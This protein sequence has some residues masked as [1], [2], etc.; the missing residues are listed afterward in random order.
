[1][2]IQ[3]CEKQQCL[4]ECSLGNR[5]EAKINTRE[6]TPETKKHTEQR[7]QKSQLS[8]FLGGME[9]FISLS[10][11]PSLSS[12]FLCLPFAQS[13]I[14]SA[15]EKGPIGGWREIVFSEEML[16]APTGGGEDISH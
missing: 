7:R 6:S 11:S 12:S 10:L 13:V 3:L 8:G 16:I 4:S 2:E 15:I 9:S 5:Q 14:L 1:M